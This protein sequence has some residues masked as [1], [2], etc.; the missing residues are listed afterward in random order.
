MTVRT[1]F[2]PSPTG[3]LHLGSVRTALYNW[4]YARHSGGQ[5]LLRVED[6]DA[7]RSTDESTKAIFDGFQWLGLVWDEA[8]V[9]QSQRTELY[10]DALQQLWQTNKAYPAFETEAEL[11]A[12]REAAEA[13]K[14]TYIYSGSS[15]ALSREAAE[16]RIMAGERFVWR[17]CVGTVGE[18][19]V[20]ESLM[21]A[22]GEV[23]TPNAEIGDFPLTRSGTHNEGGGAPLYN[24]CNVVDDHAQGVTHVVR[25][26]EHLGNAARQA[27]IYRAFGWE[28][29]SFTHLPLILKGGKKMSKRDPDPLFT[30]SVAE[31]ERRGF[32]PEALL[33]YM[34]LL[35]F[36]MPDDQEF[37]SLDD[38]IRL[39]DLGRLSKSNANFDEDKF[40]HFNALWIRHLA[41]T[42]AA[43]LAQRL[44]SFM[45]PV[46]A[47]QPTDRRVA[48]VQLVAD[49]ARLLTDF[50]PLLAHFADGAGDLRAD[51]KAATL[52]T[53][54][55]A[56]HLQAVAGLL[57][58]TELYDALTL[59]T[60]V[61]EWATTQGLKPKAY[62][63]ALRLALTGSS[64]S[65]GGVFDI[66]ALLG[67][68]EAVT[69]LRRAEALIG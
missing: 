69:R 50:V 68:E 43:G 21:S 38:L 10:R 36:S 61:K 42:D 11:Q 49:R 60:A 40:Q 54:E 56:P 67:R 14:R 1:R 47:E 59:E 65:A 58:A 18:T 57:E 53:A 62:M 12:A 15:A 4:L 66:A 6:T 16:N 35:G 17:L 7:A 13:D 48:L 5:Y 20:R 3:M 37:A 51:E 25:G 32:L 19:R 45:P 29:P 52:L 28:E 44:D 8:P 46:W 30:V 9:Y 26:V 23:V 41:Q 27:L 31:R 55:I 2:A 34:A 24:F 22:N 39:F 63:M 64:H 33:N